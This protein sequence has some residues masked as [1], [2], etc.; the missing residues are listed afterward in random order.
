MSTWISKPLLAALIGAALAGCDTGLPGT[1]SGSAARQMTQA[2]LAGGQIV[3]STPT[4]YCID[5]RSVR[6]SP[7]AGFAMVARCD[8]LDARG[9]SAARELALITVTTAPRPSGTALTLSDLVASAAPA[10]V[11]EKKTRGGLPMIRLETPAGSLGEVSPQHWRAAFTLNGQI[12]GLAL[13]A[14]ASSGAMTASEGA[15]VL[16]DLANR[17]RRATVNQL[18][19]TPSATKPLISSQTPPEKKSPFPAIA[20]LFE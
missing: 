5:R 11:L 1:S 16:S 20:G 4:G 19:Q 8:T 13:Y 6:K 17:T 3:L 10:R 9:F 12:V 15:A 2:E 18:S 14:P 7:K